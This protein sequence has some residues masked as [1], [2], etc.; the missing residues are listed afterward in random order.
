MKKTFIRLTISVVILFF[1]SAIL[2]TTGA[3]NIFTGNKVNYWYVSG[4]ADANMAFG[5]K[6]NKDTVAKDRGFDWDLE[7]GARDK[8]FGVYV[9]YG[10]FAKFDYVTYG[11]GVDYYVDWLKN[12]QLSF[13][14][15]FNKKS[16]ITLIED[17]S[18]SAGIYTSFV[19]R[20][21][22]QGNQGSF[23]A[24]V[25]PRGQIILWNG[26]IGLLLA[27]K[28]QRRPELQKFKFEGSIGIVVKFDR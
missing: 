1:T 14:N 16:R 20:K 25:S 22:T 26:D 21:D 7:L 27:S 28:Y 18:L 11:T 24:H 5:F 12:T 6:D 2:N 17:I 8:H 9:F 4:S 23:W 3:Q 15:P 13:K 10:Q 19:L